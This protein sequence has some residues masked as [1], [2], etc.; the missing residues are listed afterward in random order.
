MKN[1]LWILAIVLVI[2]LGITACGDSGGGDGGGG[3]PNTPTVA[4][5]NIIDIGI[6]TH[7]GNPKTVTITPKAGKS[8]GTITVYYNGSTVVPSDVGTYTVTF[9]V[10]AAEGWNAV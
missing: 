5:F 2:G 6:V 1:A 7:D 3:D 8:T 10:A 4:D 9:N